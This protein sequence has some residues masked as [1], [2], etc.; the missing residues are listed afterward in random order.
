MPEML[1]NKVLKGM[2]N[3]E[4]IKTAADKIRQVIT[5]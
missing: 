2:S 4:C 5:S 3:A 1:Q